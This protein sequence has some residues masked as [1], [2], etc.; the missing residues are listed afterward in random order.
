MKLQVYALNFVIQHWIL[1][2]VVA[3]KD[4]VR[5]LQEYQ[6]VNEITFSNSLKFPHFTKIIKYFPNV[7]LDS[8]GYIKKF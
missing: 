1:T 6:E 4:L 7:L 2:D 5:V 8:E 3:Q